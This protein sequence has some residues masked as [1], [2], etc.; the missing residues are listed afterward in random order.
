MKTSWTVLFSVVVVVAAF[1]ARANVAH[2]YKL[3]SS[4]LFVSSVG[5]VTSNNGDKKGSADIVLVDQLIT[6]RS[7]KH[8]TKFSCSGNECCCSVGSCDTA[9]CLSPD[10]CKNIGGSC[11]STCNCQ[12]V[13]R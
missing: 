11:S 5:T 1:G 9:K 13:V 8:Q 6:F 7:D 3:V 4:T 2:P 10:D 12:A